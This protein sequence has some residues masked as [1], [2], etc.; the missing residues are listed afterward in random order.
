MVAA[1]DLPIATTLRPEHL[2]LAEWPA[3]NQP[4]GVLRNVKELVGRVVISK[5]V[6]SEPILASKLAS[7]LAMKLAAHARNAASRAGRLA[8]KPVK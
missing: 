3:S 5:I 7:K 2:R 1:V 8:G 6:Q 4:Q